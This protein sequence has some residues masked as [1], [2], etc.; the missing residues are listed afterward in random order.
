MKIE[1]LIYIYGAV[2]V[3]MILFNIIYSLLIKHSRPQLVKRCRALENQ[4]LPQIERLRKGEAVE[5]KHLS[6]LECSMRRI[7]NLMAYDCV[8]KSTI[9]NGRENLKALYLF[10]IQPALLYL[11]LFYQK[12]DSM[13]AAYFAYFLSRYMAPD[14]MNIR[15]IQ[16][17]LLEYVRKENL[18]C[19]VNAL[20]ALY[21]FGN[22]ENV[23]RALKIQDQ[24]E[25]FIH[26]K[27]LT[28]G[29][30][31][32]SGDHAV[33]IGRL[34]TE[35]DHFSPRTQ[36]AISNYIRF[37]SGN[38]VQE[39]LEVLED[40]TKDKEIRLSAIRYFGRYCY[41]PALPQLLFFVQQLDSTYWEYATVSASS[42]AH[43]AGDQVISALKNAL[44]SSNWYVRSAAATSLEAH[45]VG[46]EDMMD[47]IS[48]N[49]RYAREMI[50]YHLEER[51][52]QK[53]GVGQ[54]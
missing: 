9:W 53:E 50:L 18:Y 10:Q 6:N 37:Y 22:A 20:Q 3:S 45:G 31:T 49:D 47:I 26:E 51:E 11:A 13:S 4:I 15:P 35:L 52:I 25:V 28:E 44:H 24:G 43:Y 29:L 32:F 36:L 41:E 54:K 46:Y 7:K 12:R 19:R 40:N 14:D 33:L 39:M 8:L 42:L 2:C 38:Y 30:L 48:G 21:R 34:W 1:S 27:I 23:L 17:V 5:K 16:E